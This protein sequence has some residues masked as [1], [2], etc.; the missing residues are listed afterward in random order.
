MGGSGIG[1]ADAVLRLGRSV[2]SGSFGGT[3]A[4][5]PPACSIHAAQC[6]RT[7]PQVG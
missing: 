1:A 6:E 4:T 5:T 2:G 3:G 7:I